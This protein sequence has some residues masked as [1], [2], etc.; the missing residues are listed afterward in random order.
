MA[1][2]TGDYILLMNN[3]VVVTP[4]WLERMI[5]CAEKRPEIGIVGPRS[6]Y[7]SGPQLVEGVDYYTHTL[8]GLVEF[9]NNLADDHADKRSIF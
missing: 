5:C 3:D 4:G 7:V 8:N 2:A 9:S 1:A 6:N